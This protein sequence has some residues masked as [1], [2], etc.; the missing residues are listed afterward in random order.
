MVVRTGASHLISAIN[1]DLLPPTPA[2]LVPER[3]L[4][5]D[6]H[7][8][9][10]ARPDWTPPAE[11]HV[12]ELIAFAESWDRQAP[13]LIH[14]WRNTSTAAAFTAVRLVSACGKGDDR[15]LRRYRQR[16]RPTACS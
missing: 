3:H 1:A 15:A 2:T 5:L 13:L 12:A 6:M 16:R 4:K 14:S 11:R 7:D 10:E 8:I 9:V